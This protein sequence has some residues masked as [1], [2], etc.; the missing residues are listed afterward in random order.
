MLPQRVAADITRSGLDIRVIE[1]D[2][3]RAYAICARVGIPLHLREDP[4]PRD[5]LANMRGLALSVCTN[6]ML[7]IVRRVEVLG[8]V[9]NVLCVYGLPSIVL[10]YY[11]G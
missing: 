3:R 6:R 4:I 11:D 5:A 7:A 9:S 10:A 1:A 8:L 2:L